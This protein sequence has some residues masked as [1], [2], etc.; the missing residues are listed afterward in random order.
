MQTRQRLTLART[1]GFTMLE[2]VVVAAILAILAGM[3]M[4]VTPAVLARAKADSGAARLLSL[5]RTTREQ[6]ISQRRNIRVEFLDGNRFLVTRIDVPGPGTTTLLDTRLEQN[7]QF[8]RY[9]GLPDTPDLFGAAGAVDFG[10]AVSF[11][12]TS[13]GTF[14]DQNGDELN[15]TVFLGLPDQVETAQAVTIF[16]PT[17]TMRAWRWTGAQWVE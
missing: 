16:G 13:E 2:L 12:F 14:V 7:L 17:G 3:A 5:L 1:D 8:I 4:M 6:S 9:P 10:P 15:G 11:T